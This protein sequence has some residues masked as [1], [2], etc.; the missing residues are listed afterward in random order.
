MSSFFSL[1]RRGLVSMVTGP[2]LVAVGLV[3]GVRLMALAGLAVLVW[4]GYRF[5]TARGAGR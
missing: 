2:V 1:Y 3:I 4:G 5:I